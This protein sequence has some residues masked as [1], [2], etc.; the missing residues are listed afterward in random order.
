MSKAQPKAFRR[1]GKIVIEMPE[2]N[3]VFAVENSP[4]FNAK[5]TDREAY[6]NGVVDN[7]LE[8]TSGTDDDPL[9]FRLLD[10]VTE[11]MIESSADGIEPA[12]AEG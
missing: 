1:G 7:L 2:D 5:I 9:F 12:D 6:L 11:E 8:Y 3:L 4:R 10:D